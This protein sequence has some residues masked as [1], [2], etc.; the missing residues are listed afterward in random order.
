MKVGK[1]S[2]RRLPSGKRAAANE[3]GTLV[4]ADEVQ[5]GIGTLD[6]YFLMRIVRSS[7]ILLRLRK[8]WQEGSRLEQ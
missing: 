3:F 4:I 8:A 2:A 6:V 7:Q 1:T 5:A